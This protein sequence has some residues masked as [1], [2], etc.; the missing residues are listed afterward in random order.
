MLKKVFPM[1]DTYLKSRVIMMSYR[2]N[3]V[4][5]QIAKNNLD[6]SS[7]YFSSNDPM[8]YYELNFVS[9]LVQHHSADPATMT[10]A[11]AEKY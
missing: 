11:E 9:Y 7:N 3:P 5:I 2:A 10:A 4:M 6:K 1:L 8:H